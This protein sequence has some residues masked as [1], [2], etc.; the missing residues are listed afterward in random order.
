MPFDSLSATSPV[1]EVLREGR[2]R[3]ERG[4]CQHVGY[5]DGRRCVMTA[6]VGTDTPTVKSACTALY[7][8]GGF[9]D[10][11]DAVTWNDAPDRTQADVLALYDKAIDIAVAEEMEKR[12]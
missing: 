10:N 2:A 4:W 5:T 11:A 9:K 8:A 6:M 12:T 1:I 3:I 7:K